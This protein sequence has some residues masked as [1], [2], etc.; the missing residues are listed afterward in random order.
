MNITQE[1]EEL[2]KIFGLSEDNPPNQRKIKNIYW[3]SDAGLKIF[4]DAV[5]KDMEKSGITIKT[6]KNEH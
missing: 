1:G 3:M 5:K 4:N 6:N 2:A